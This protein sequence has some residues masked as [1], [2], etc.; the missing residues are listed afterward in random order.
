MCILGGILFMWGIVS[1]FTFAVL[2]S[3]SQKKPDF[4]TSKIENALFMG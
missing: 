4:G 2:M 1:S 3:A